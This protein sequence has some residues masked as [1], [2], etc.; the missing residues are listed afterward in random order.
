MPRSTSQLAA[1][2]TQPGMSCSGSQFTGR[3]RLSIKAVCGKREVRRSNCKAYWSP[4]IFWRSMKSRRQPNT[5]DRSGK[6]TVASIQASSVCFLRL[7]MSRRIVLQV[8]NGSYV[9]VFLSNL[10]LLER[11]LNQ[12]LESR[13][14]QSLRSSRLC[15]GTTLLRLTRYTT[16][17][18][19]QHVLCSLLLSHHFL[20]LS[21][22]PRFILYCQG[23]RQA[24]EKRRGCD[25][26]DE[27][28]CEKRTC[29]SV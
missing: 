10:H 2:R 27:F 14:T 9:F 13:R 17:S 23:K 18:G 12:H 1:I 7:S 16:C 29:E 11:F 28:S 8:R 3:C 6:R 25:D 4:L 26:P 19:G 22:D 24:D 15:R 21:H 5:Q 20:L